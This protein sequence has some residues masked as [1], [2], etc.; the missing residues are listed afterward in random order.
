MRITVVETTYVRL[1]LAFPYSGGERLSRGDRPHEHTGLVLVRLR[2]DAGFEGVGEIHVKGG[3]PEGHGVKRFVDHV[4]APVVIGADPRELQPLLQRLRM[5][6]LHQSTVHVAGFD[7]ALYDLLGHITSLPLW[8]LL[9]GRVREQVPL[10]WNVPATRDLDWMEEQARLA[11]TR[12][13]Q[14]V[15]KVKTGTPWDVEALERVQR[16]AGSVPLRPDDNGAFL[17]SESIQRFH[18]ARERGVRFELLEQPAPNR[19]LAGLRQ[20]GVALGERVM[21]HTGYLDPAIAARLLEQRFADVVSIPVFRH[22]IWE[23]VQL[24]RTFEVAG[25]GVTM[26][27]GLEGTI[28]A[29]AA[30]HVASAVDALRF[31]IDTLGPLWCKEDIVTAPPHFATGYAVAP[32]GPGLGL[33][34]DWECVREFAVPDN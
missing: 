34:V 18:A 24:M 27:S 28:A 31:P 8:A 20:V 6:N 26:G 22:G 17:A 14:H 23:A 7:I 13:F 4:L 15:I 16:G 25:I 5:A 30:I 12:G 3:G 1:P 10:T 19:D 33:E 11:V 9:G 21:Y 29:T 2:T 32:A